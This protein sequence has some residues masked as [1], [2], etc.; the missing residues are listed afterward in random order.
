MLG[1]EVVAELD[2][3]GNR[4]ASY[5]Y[6]NGMQLAKDQV[7]G[8]PSGAL[9]TWQYSDPVTGSTGSTNVQRDYLGMTEVDPLGADVTSPP[10]VNLDGSNYAEPVFSD[11]IK[12]TYF[13]IEGGPSDSF[14]V[15][16]WYVNM[17]NKGFDAWNAQRFYDHG[18]T[19]VAQGIV[20][21]NPNVGFI[22][23]GKGAQMLAELA[24]GA[25]KNSDGSFTFWGAK[26]ARALGLI[27]EV[28][29][30]SSDATGTTR[31]SSNGGCSIAVQLIGERTETINTALGTT[32]A[33]GFKFRVS[34]HVNSSQIGRIGSPNA[35]AKRT[36]LGN[37]PNGGAW[38]IGQ[39]VFPQYSVAKYTD[40]DTIATVT[41]NPYVAGME[42]SPYPTY[43]KIRGRDFSWVDSPGFT[44]S[45]RDHQ[46][47]SADMSSTFM[48]YAQSGQERC[49]VKFRIEETFTNG[50]WH[51]SVH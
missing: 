18:F 1:G 45:S 13:Q 40:G 25:E 48:V 19:D 17:V 22:A 47:L 32:V 33:E 21:N 43:R 44:V 12:Q 29:Q 16:K 9:V 8:W 49:L 23:S 31:R 7:G 15:D 5:V 36:D 39:L 2:A 28:E 46:L 3:Q 24:G 34:G 10:P 42:D 26:A 20:A 37:L 4:I 11:P 30:M 14:G 50:K 35:E 41:N 27:S 6:M 38:T 51:M